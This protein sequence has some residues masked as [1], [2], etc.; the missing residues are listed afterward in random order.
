MEM[1]I[2][3]VKQIGR[4]SFMPMKQ[5]NQ[6]NHICAKS[7]YCTKIMHPNEALNL[8]A[9]KLNTVINIGAFTLGK[10]ND[11]LRF[12]CC[13]DRYALAQFLSDL[14]RSHPTIALL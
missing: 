9:P 4:A 3:T 6:A 13:I 1:S 7:F 10:P 11:E 12:L 14:H 5:K 2:S 8:L